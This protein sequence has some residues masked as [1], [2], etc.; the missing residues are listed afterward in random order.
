MAEEPRNVSNMLRMMSH[1]I[2][3][4][5]VSISATLR[6]LS[7]GYYGKMDEVVMNRL[8]ELLSKIIGL[9][10][11]TEEYLSRTISINGDGEPGD[12]I[13]D[14]MRDIINPVMQELDPELKERTIWIDRRIDS[15][16]TQQTLIKANRACLKSVFRNL[17][18]N[19][20]KYGDKEGTIAIAF[21]DCGFLYRLSIYNRGNPIPEEYRN[22]IFTRFARFGNNE[23]GGMGGMGLG[24]YLAKEIIQAYGG[25]IW[26]Q[27]EED[28]S[29]FVFTLP[30]R[31]A[32]SS[33]S[34]EPVEP[35]Q[36]RLGAGR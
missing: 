21:E 18:K 15:I 28:G 34:L 29:N 13:L 35:A 23:D 11:I 9:I 36:P 24:L 26:Y 31:L 8:N 14:L 20:I 3:G 27:A 12:E 2:R 1:D 33:D 7:R 17:L 16:P 6:L 25:D 5:L 32:F 19:A 30:A 22:K 4:S 10:G